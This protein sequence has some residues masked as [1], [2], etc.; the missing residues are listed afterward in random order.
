M[1]ISDNY[2]VQYLLQGTRSSAGPIVWQDTDDEGYVTCLNGIRVV[3]DSIVT[4]TG[5][6]YFLTFS[7][8][9]STCTGVKVQVVE[10]VNAGLFRAKYENEDH[11]RLAELLQELSVAISQQCSARKRSGVQGADPVREALYRRLLDS[12]SSET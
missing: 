1:P 11:R 6:R 8:A 5:S 3:F 4:R 9:A 2:V 10:P 12:H 7:C